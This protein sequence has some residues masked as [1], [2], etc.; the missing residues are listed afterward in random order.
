ML[1][2][3]QDHLRIG[4]RDLDHPISFRRKNIDSWHARKED[5]QSTSSLYVP[6]VPSPK[7]PFV[8]N[9]HNPTDVSLDPGSTIHFGRLEFTID[10]LG[11][12]SLSP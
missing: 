5:L 7:L 10:R 9:V 2:S 12:L 6:M 4:M 8:A 1:C 11:C 3:S